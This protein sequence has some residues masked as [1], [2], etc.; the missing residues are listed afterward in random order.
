M[1]ININRVRTDTYGSL[2]SSLSVQN[3]G[4]GIKSEQTAVKVFSVKRRIK[5]ES[6]AP[7][8]EPRLDCLGCPDCLV[9]SCIRQMDNQNIPKRKVSHCVTTDN[10]SIQSGNTFA[11]PERP[12]SGSSVIDPGSQNGTLLPAPSIISENRAATTGYEVV[13]DVAGGGV[14]K[15]FTAEE[16]AETLRK[17]TESLITSLSYFNISRDGYGL[18]QRDEMTGIFIDFI[19]YQEGLVNDR[20]FTVESSPDKYVAGKTLSQAQVE[21]IQAFLSDIFTERSEKCDK[22]GYSPI[23]RYSLDNM[24]VDYLNKKENVPDDLIPTL[25]IRDQRKFTYEHLLENIFP[26]FGILLA[27]RGIFSELVIIFNFAVKFRQELIDSYA[28]CPLN[29]LLTVGLRTN[30]SDMREYFNSHVL[31]VIFLRRCDG[32]INTLFDDYP[33]PAESVVNP[34]NQLNLK[35]G[36]ELEYDVIEKDPLSASWH[37]L[38]DIFASQLQGKGMTIYSP[39]NDKAADRYGF[40][41]SFTVTPFYDTS[42]WFE[43]NCTPYHSDNPRAESCF[44]KVIEVIDSMRNDGLLGYSSGHKHVD[45]LSA[46]QGDTGVLLA[47]ESEIQRNPFLLRA[48]GNN[49]RIVQKNETRWYKTFADYNPDTKPFAVKRL[50][51][52]IDRYNKKID[53]Y[54]AEKLRGKGNTDSKKD[55]LKQFAHFYSQFVHMTTIQKGLGSSCD[56]HMEK[57]MAMTLLHITGASNVSELSTLEFRFFRCPKTVQEIKLINQFLQAWF[58]YI[59][60]CRKDKVPLEPVPEDIK[61]CKDYTAEQVQAKTIDY[62][63]KLGLDP[64]EY[65]CFWGEVRDLPASE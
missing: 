37:R 53:A 25:S 63:K 39:S 36:E 34:A 62:L 35:F 44:E 7:K 30:K 49:D 11:S 60:Q 32:I 43:I 33:L 27:G 29:N 5:D 51:L 48:F 47:L 65:R 3:V 54:C 64:E 38:D 18:D 8:R 17:T 20:C 55:R 41:H 28:Q 13:V 45:A 40:D 22:D 2:E 14:S 59:H 4:K 46:T 52:M 6:P 26:F 61:S 50:N 58:Q 9:P 57:F 56:G 15:T 23:L 1:D 24:L 12:Y 10:I 42:E 19:L 16:A 31:D 21:E